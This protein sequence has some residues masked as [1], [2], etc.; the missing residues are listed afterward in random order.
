MS[1]TRESLPTDLLKIQHQAIADVT[2]PRSHQTSLALLPPPPETHPSSTEKLDLI[3]QNSNMPP[4]AGYETYIKPGKRTEAII[5]TLRLNS[6][7]GQILDLFIQH[8]HDP[9][10]EGIFAPANLTPEETSIIAS[11]IRALQGDTGPQTEYPSWLFDELELT[12]ATSLARQAVTILV[13]NMFNR[14]DC[15]FEEAT[16]LGNNHYQSL[17]QTAQIARLLRFLDQA[18]VIYDP[19]GMPARRSAK[20]PLNANR[21]LNILEKVATTSAGYTQ[22]FWQQTIGHFPQN[23]QELEHPVGYIGHIV[24]AQ[25][26]GVILPFPKGFTKENLDSVHKGDQKSYSPQEAAEY[27]Y[28]TLINGFAAMAGSLA[29][30]EP[31]DNHPLAAR[32]TL[33]VTVPRFIGDDLCDLF[34]DPWQSQPNPFSAY[35]LTHYTEKPSISPEAMVGD[36]YDYYLTGTHPQAEA[37]DTSSP[38]LVISAKTGTISPLSFKTPALTGTPSE[39]VIQSQKLFANLKTQ[40]KYLGEAAVIIALPLKMDDGSTT[41]RTLKLTPNLFGLPT[42]SRFAVETIRAADLQN[43]AD[44]LAKN[45]RHPDEWLKNTDHFIV[46]GE[47]IATSQKDFQKALK[48]GA[49]YLSAHPHRRFAHL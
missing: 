14:L 40:H 3:R 10:P 15:M 37:T 22:E 46:N 39:I 16:D 42:I 27:R 12:P 44:K 34:Q 5:K 35:A 17:P 1:Q 9:N 31:I 2:A 23:P 43:L 4:R 8:L 11:G 18:E 32:K 36:L 28:H 24:A 48:E 7:T 45:P 21:F 26:R 30:G 49:R 38:I 41:Y 33:R 20:T 29:L 6:T 13:L 47:Y 25:I 19:E